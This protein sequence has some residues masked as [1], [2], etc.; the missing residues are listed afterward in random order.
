M[1]CW[2]GGMMEW[3]GRGKLETGGGNWKL[4]TGN[5]GEWK[6]SLQSCKSCQKS[7]TSTAWKTEQPTTKFAKCTKENWNSLF[8]YE[9]HEWHEWIEIL[10]IL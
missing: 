10:S 4:E 8:N 3:W 9:S 5:L 6:S 1:E 7:G 2:N